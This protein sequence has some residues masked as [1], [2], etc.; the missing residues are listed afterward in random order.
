MAFIQQGL[1][2]E[3]LALC[4]SLGLVIGIFPVLGSTTILCAAAAFFF[5][6]N[7][8][9]MQSVNY[10]AYPL[11]LALLIPWYRLGEH[12]FRVKPLGLSAAD[13]KAIFARGIPYAVHT[14]WDVTIHAVAAWLLWAPFA[15]AILYFFLRGLFFKLVNE[16]IIGNRKPFRT[17]ILTAGLPFFLAA[18][19]QSAD[20]PL[21]RQADALYAE[22]SEATQDLRALDLY[23]KALIETPVNA[24]LYWKASRACWWAGTRSDKRADK[25]RLFEKG[26]D[27]GKRAVQK[28]P[29]AVEPHFWLGSNYASYAHSKGAFTSLVLIK[30]IRQEMNETSKKDESYLYGGA[31]RVLGILDYMVPGF[32]GGNRERAIAHLKKAL[33]YAPEHPVTR[34]YNAAGKDYTRASQELE[35]LPRIKIPPELDPE[36]RIIQPERAALSKTL[37]DHS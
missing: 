5:R 4:V 15:V 24:S 34:F 7:Q 16:A 31:D 14:L 12:L 36:W 3:K 32:A 13:V 30:R 6:L 18:V 19:S 10:L 35:A 21:M 33:A 25:L 2:P 22:R 23:E 37:A 27:Y 26:I 28:N 1:M 11:Q 29:S 20:M 17:I 8:P 9:A